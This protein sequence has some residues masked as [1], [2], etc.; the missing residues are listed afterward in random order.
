[1]YAEGLEGN[2]EA[3]VEGEWSSG[4]EDEED[5]EEDDEEYEEDDEEGYEEDEEEYE[6]DDEE[7]E[8]AGQGRCAWGISSP[9]PSVPNAPLLPCPVTVL[10]TPFLVKLIFLQYR[11]GEKLGSE[12]YATLKVTTDIKTGKQYVC[13]VIS[14][15]ATRGRAH[16]VSPSLSFSFFTHESYSETQVQSEVTVL[17]RVRGN[18]LN[19]VKIHDCFEVGFVY[20]PL[21]DLIICCIDIQARISVLESVHRRYTF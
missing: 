6:E 1:M 9:L 2:E 15:E 10:Q 17:K 11:I 12:P 5:N 21:F 8:L 4:E 3:E 7:D 19:I 14:K 18:N 20:I 16:L 13:K